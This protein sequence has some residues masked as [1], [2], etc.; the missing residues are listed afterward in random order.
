MLR[1]LYPKPLNIALTPIEVGVSIMLVAWFCT[2]VIAYQNN[3]LLKRLIVKLD[4]LSP[5]KNWGVSD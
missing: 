3:T 4:C 2:M 5:P 1:V